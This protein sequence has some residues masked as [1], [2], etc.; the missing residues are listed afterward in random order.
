MV[1]TRWRL[2]EAGAAGLMTLATHS[3][4]LRTLFSTPP[5]FPMA[6]NPTP[7]NDHVLLATCDRLAGGCH[8]LEVEIGIKQNTEEKV[9]ADLA[10]AVA[11]SQALG[12]AKSTLGKCRTALR[13][14]D[15]DGKR[16]LR[17]CRLRLAQIFGAKFSSSW[18]AAGYRNHSSAVPEM[19]GKR[20][21]LLGSLSAYF[22]AT[23]AHESADMGATAAICHAAHEAHSDARS[24]MNQAKSALRTAVKEKRRAFKALRQ[25]MRGLI[26]ELRVVLADNDPRWLRFGLKLPVRI[27]RPDQVQQ[28]HLTALGKGRIQVEWTHASRATRFRIQVRK[29]DVEGAEFEN[30]KTVND[31]SLL[32]KVLLSGFTPGETIEVQVIAAN[33]ADEARPSPMARVVAT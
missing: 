4:A 8:A 33:E 14:A 25:R 30:A 20:L 18:E 29:A 22:T 15:A 17:H 27:A 16:V 10:T 3:P 24:A 6:A 19:H 1:A 13:K 5:T 23:P 31:S 2:A 26:Q 9:R 11:A 28:V 21:S 7:T 32:P 12:E